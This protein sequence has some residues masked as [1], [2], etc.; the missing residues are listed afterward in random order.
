MRLS[1]FLF[2]LCEFDL[3]NDEFDMMLLMGAL[4]HL[5]EN[6]MICKQNIVV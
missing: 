2:R 6:Y 3:P 5:Q 1:T 4:Y